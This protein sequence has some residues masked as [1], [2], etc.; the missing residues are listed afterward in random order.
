MEECGVV[1]SRVNNH[2]YF[3]LK[4][5]ITNDQIYDG[6]HIHAIILM[7]EFIS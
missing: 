6:S 1:H 2:E 5:S 7:Y 3:D 4:H